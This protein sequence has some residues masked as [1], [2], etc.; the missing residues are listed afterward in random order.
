MSIA[1]TSMH[2]PASRPIASCCP[3]NVGQSERT[4]SLV[5]GSALALAGLSRGSLSGMILAATGGSLIYRGVTGK[6]HLYDAF[7][8]N[9]AE[10]HNAATAVPAQQGTKI[11]HSIT[12]NRPHQDLYRYWRNFENLPRIMNHLES[13]KATTGNRSHWVAKAPLG[14]TVEWDAEV[15]NE[16]DGELIAWRSLDGSQVETA[17]SVH[18]KPALAGRGTEVTVSLKYNPPGGKVGIAVAKMFGEEPQQ[19]IAE[20]LNR[21]KQLMESGAAASA[22]KG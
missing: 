18:F 8:I 17:G 11:E 15:I 6:C 21:F 1:N 9:T 14:T 12:I 2:T 22:S 13:V 16:R 4:I 19:Q 20:D 5:A 3:V 7:G 10:G